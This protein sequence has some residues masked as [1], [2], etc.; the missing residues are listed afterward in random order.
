MATPREFLPA[1]IERTS[2]TTGQIAER[3]G[4]ALDY[5]ATQVGVVGNIT[6]SYDPSLGAPGLNLAEQLLTS[7]LAPYSDMESF[8]GIAGGAVTIIISPLSTAHDGSAGAY[9][10]GCDFTSGGTIYI[11]ATFNAPSNALDLE[12]ALYVAELSEAFMGAQN[13]GW[14]C[15]FSNGEGLSR[16][17]A[18]IETPL[19]TLDGFI[20]APSWAAAGFPDWVNTT[21]HTDRNSVSTG[22]AILYI[23]WMYSLGYTT[24]RITRAGGAT[25]AAN[26]QTLTGKTTAYTDFKAAVQNLTINNDNPFSP[27]QTVFCASAWSSNRLDI[28]GTGLDNAEYHKWWDGSNWGGWESLGGVLTGNPSSVSW[29]SNRLDIFAR[30]TDAAMYH[31]WWDGSGWGGWESLGGFITGDPKAV[32][33]GPGRLDIFA[34]G[35]DDA[36]WHRW[37]D[38][39]SWGGWESLGG[40]LT[41]NFAPV[42]WGPNRLDIFGRG[43]DGALYHRWWDGSSWGGWESLGGIITSDPSA[44]AWGPNRLDIFA[45]GTD[46]AMWHRWWD[47]SNWGGW[48]SLGGIIISNPTAV[49]WGPNRLD[50]F[51]IGTDGGMYHRWWDGSAWGGWEARGGVFTSAP[52]AVSWAA[53][54]LDVFGLGTDKVPYHAAWDGSNW[55]GWESLG[56]ELEGFPQR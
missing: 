45:R 29:A 42:S 36:M 30:G 9:H 53:N 32:S 38:G 17:L 22:C 4:D 26:Y 44:V 51:A 40:I 7:V 46:N 52:V 12:V 3:L 47:G 18:E 6:V 49:S 48:E 1:G 25:L 43:T 31:R 16:Y 23:Y 35:T 20:T 33:W 11:D 27:M 24:T 28:F 50:I 14:G 21:E 55:S 41:S 8:F 19:G 10:Y 56:G 54:R 34:R 2:R 39:S 5:P 37:W 15:G 13:L